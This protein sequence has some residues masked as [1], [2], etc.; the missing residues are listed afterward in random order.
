LRACQADPILTRRNGPLSAP[1]PGLRF[2][3]AGPADAEAIAAL[4][5]DS[6]QRHYRVAF[7]G[8]Y[9]D[10]E[11]PG[12]HRRRWTERLAKPDPRART[13]LAEHDDGTLAGFA[14]TILGDDPAWGA[15][16]D[17]LHVTY[18]LKRHGI[19]T[20]LMALTA[21]TVLIET[22]G[23][24]LYLWVL[25]PNTGARAFYTARG[26]ECVERVAVEPPG[27]DPAKLNGTPFGLRFAW[28]DPSVLVGQSPA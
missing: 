13:I 23:S 26:G 9:L 8:T 16:L 12:I 28:R 18:G 3:S 10:D 21:R 1:E 17:N 14:H 19:G 20:R 7:S 22:P 24:G 6:W 25:E 5:T 15:L 11:V 27:G 2:R 4:H